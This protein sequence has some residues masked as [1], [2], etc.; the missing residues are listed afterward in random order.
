MELLHSSAAEFFQSSATDKQVIPPTIHFL[1]LNGTMVKDMDDLLLHMMPACHHASQEKGVVY[2]EQKSIL[3]FFLD[4]W[5]L[6]HALKLKLMLK[7]ASC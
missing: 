2:R 3:A 4:M 1:T 7:C 6:L 5:T